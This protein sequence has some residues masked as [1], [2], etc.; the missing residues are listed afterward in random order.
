MEQVSA[1]HMAYMRRKSLD[2]AIA[3]LVKTVESIGGATRRHFMP[4]QV[5]GDTV[6]VVYNEGEH[7]KEKL[8]ARV[9]L[10]LW[11]KTGFW[12]WKKNHSLL[13]N[14][15]FDFIFGVNSPEAQVTSVTSFGQDYT[16]LATYLEQLIGEEDAK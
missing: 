13:V 10:V 9:S 14:Y 5:V 4:T 1:E 16:E 8:T 11:R 3:H 6:S 15:K 12:L 2:L 7:P